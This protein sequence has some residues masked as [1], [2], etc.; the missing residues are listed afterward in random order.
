MPDNRLHGRDW[1]L[2]DLNWLSRDFHCISLCI[3][4]ATPPF[5]RLKDPL[6][7]IIEGDGKSDGLTL[8]TLF[9]FFVSA[10]IS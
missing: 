10:A 7:S 2:A 4:R 3:H 6:K 5:S 1:A 9:R 8:V